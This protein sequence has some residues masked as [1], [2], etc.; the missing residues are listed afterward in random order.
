MKQ[1]NETTALIENVLQWY[2]QH[3]YVIYRQAGSLSNKLDARLERE[4]AMRVL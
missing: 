1:K 4:V 2:Q 3:C